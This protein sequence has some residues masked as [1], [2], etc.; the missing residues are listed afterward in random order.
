MTTVF[1]DANVFLRYLARDDE[2]QHRAAERLFAAAAAGEIR[3]ITGPPV[4]FELA[5]TLRRTYGVSRQEAL[6]LVESVTGTPGLTVLDAPL[7]SAALA[8]ARA[9]SREFADSYI[10][11]SASQAESESLATFNRRDLEGSSLPLYPLD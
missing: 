7:V 6:D 1:V 4:L 3:L 2:G 9:N 5:W 10:L 8:L 11:A